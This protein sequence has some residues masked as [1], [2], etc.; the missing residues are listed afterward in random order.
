[1]NRAKNHAI[2]SRSYYGLSIQTELKIQD[3]LPDRFQKC[4][5]KKSTNYYVML[6]NNIDT[7]FEK[8]TVGIE[9]DIDIFGRFLLETLHLL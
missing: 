1:M 2:N 5:E 8:E 9:D 7:V 6:K 4:D 3:V